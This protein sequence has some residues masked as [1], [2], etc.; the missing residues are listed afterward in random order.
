MSGRIV[1]DIDV[2]IGKRIRAKR[3]SKGMSQEKL[4]DLLGV[5]FQQ[6][7]KYE[8][9]V[10]RVAAS[11]LIY[12]GRALEVSPASLLPKLEA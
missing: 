4:A 5:T 6:V 9:G 7:Q 12:I 10:N 2:Q 11:R 1:T 8:K 3:L